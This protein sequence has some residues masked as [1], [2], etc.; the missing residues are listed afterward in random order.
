MGWLKR[1]LNGI[2][3]TVSMFPDKRS[4]N[5][6]TRYSMRDIGLAAFSLFFMQNESL[7]A[8]QRRLQSER[9]RSN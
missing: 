9:G 5:G 4:G 1:R 3:E 8:H 6:R 2:G 7:L